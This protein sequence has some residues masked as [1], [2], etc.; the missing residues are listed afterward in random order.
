MSL[1]SSAFETEWVEPVCAVAWNY[2]VRLR[3]MFGR[4]E[5]PQDDSEEV[6]G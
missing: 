4:V 2:S 6:L 1:D 3:E 5:H